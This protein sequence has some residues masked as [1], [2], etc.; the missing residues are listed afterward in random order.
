MIF[1]PAI[2]LITVLLVIAAWHFYWALGGKSGL[3][4][5]LPENREGR[6]VLAPSK[7]VTFLVAAG[8]LA[9]AVFTWLRVFDN[10]PLL[11]HWMLEYGMLVI[12]AIFFLRAIGD[13]KYVGL[14]KKI[15]HSS[16]AERDSRYYTP[17]SILIAI[18]AVMI[19]VLF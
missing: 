6:K 5:V 11:P 9:M 14:L 8:L 17:L 15:R 2:F 4:R 13:F 19:D 18:V 3:S 16:F 1:I 7:L 12:A 10:D